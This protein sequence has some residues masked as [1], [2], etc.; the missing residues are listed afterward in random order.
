MS[1]DLGIRAA[2]R[3]AVERQSDHWVIGLVGFMALDMTGTPAGAVMFAQEY[4][5]DKR[6]AWHMVHFERCPHY[7][8][9]RFLHK[10]TP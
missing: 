1:I 2:V 4:N 6:D 7:A 10:V 5:G 9:R 3:A 8:P